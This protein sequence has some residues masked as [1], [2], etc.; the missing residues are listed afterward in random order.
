MSIKKE[1]ILQHKINIKVPILTTYTKQSQKPKQ[2]TVAT[3]PKN[4]TI[5]LFTLVTKAFIKIA[6]LYKF[7][8]VN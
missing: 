2:L 5:V 4:G 3:I 7:R 6:G 8:A 1:I